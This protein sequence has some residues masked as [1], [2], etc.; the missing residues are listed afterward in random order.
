MSPSLRNDIERRSIV[1]G[2]VLKA[3]NQ[4]DT[5]VLAPDIAAQ[6]NTEWPDVQA[7]IDEAIRNPRLYASNDRKNMAAHQSLLSIAA[8]YHLQTSPTDQDGQRIFA[9]DPGDALDTLRSAERLRDPTRTIYSPMA[10]ILRSAGVNFNPK[11][12]DTDLAAETAAAC[13]QD[14]MDLSGSMR[15]IQR[16]WKS[17]GVVIGAYADIETGT[18]TQREVHI[19]ENFKPS[20]DGKLQR[21][22]QL[23][24]DLKRLL[25]SLS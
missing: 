15:S 10:R 25:L 20:S 13:N 21:Q 8:A 11:S 2:Y 12:Y 23:V 1:T 17:S 6:F 5:A 3:V 7:S 4:P 19:F 22:T 18:V 9:F 24:A 14:V 16:V